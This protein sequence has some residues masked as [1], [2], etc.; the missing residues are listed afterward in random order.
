M[1]D[2]TVG[3]IPVVLPLGV[4][5]GA[6]HKVIEMVKLLLWCVEKFNRQTTHMVDKS[7]KA[8]TRFYGIFLPYHPLEGGKE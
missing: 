7:I 5:L 6:C 8:A 1:P 4:V 2:K 3:H